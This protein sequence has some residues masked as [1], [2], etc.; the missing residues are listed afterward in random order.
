MI[1]VI[2]YLLFILL[3]ASCAT[4]AYFSLRSRR[5]SNPTERGMYGAQMNILMGVML[6]I[7]SIIFMFIFKG[8]TPAIIVEALFLILGAFNIFAGIRNRGFYAN[9]K[10]NI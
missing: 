9:Q 7:L 4:S 5:S 1:T 2:K 10:T 8:S 3:I 6:V